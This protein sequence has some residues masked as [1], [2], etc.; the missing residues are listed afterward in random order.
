M[1]TTSSLSALAA[2]AIGFGLL[3]T[4]GDAP[5]RPAPDRQPAT[6]EK[7]TLVPN[8]TLQD[9]ALDRAVTVD[10]KDASITEVLNWL[11]EKGVNFVA[12]TG[13]AKQ[14]AKLTMHIV[15]RPIRE[16]LDAVA[17]TFGGKWE[18]RGSTF[19]FVSG[20]DNPLLRVE[21]LKELENLPKIQIPL[22]GLEK[23][24][25]MMPFQFDEKGMIDPKHMQDFEKKMKAWSEEFSK[26]FGK[27]GDSKIFMIPPGTMKEFKM[28]PEHAKQFEKHMKE[29][30]EKLGK[31]LEHKGKV[32]QFKIDEKHMNE[33][34]NKLK[35]MPQMEKELMEKL[36]VMPFDGKHMPDGAI[37]I[38]GGDIRELMKSLSPA[39]WEKH[40]KQGFLSPSDLTPAQK[41]ILG[42]FPNS[43]AFS[44]TVIIDGKKLTVKNK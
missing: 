38:G 27:E 31:E 32:F 29:L 39:Q 26:Q 33:L 19:A 13:N 36:K 35:D 1:L 4:S 23:M 10:F 11:A 40:E 20:S 44:I 41:K 9:A 24:P 21:R 18:K 15:N 6:V 12:D 43:S 5:E 25:E 8:V 7:P 17:A 2:S 16:V 22:E 34:K 14:N 3:G 42:E 37:K 30:H 28:D